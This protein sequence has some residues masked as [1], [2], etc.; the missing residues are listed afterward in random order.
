MAA[1]PALP[2]R[3]EKAL[4]RS[5]G[6]HGAAFAAAPGQQQAVEGPEAEA[7]TRP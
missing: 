3:H 7:A 2:P 5:R 4:G 6:D 1:G